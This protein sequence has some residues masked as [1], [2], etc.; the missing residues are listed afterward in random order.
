MYVCVCVLLRC[1]VAYDGDMA[2]SDE[3]DLAQ[4][5]C[6]GVYSAEEIDLRT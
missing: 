2:F 1:R 6:G 5:R 4:Q 3:T